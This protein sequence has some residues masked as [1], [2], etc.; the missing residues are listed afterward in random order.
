MNQ[1]ANIIDLQ[2]QASQ[3]A[4]SALD[5]I[6]RKGA[7][8]MLQTAI[9]EEVAVYIEAHQNLRDEHGHRLVVRNGHLPERVVLTGAGPLSVKKPRVDDRRDG[10]KFTSA[11]LPPYMRRSPSIDALI[12]VLYLKGVSTGDFSEALTAILGEGAGSLR[13]LYGVV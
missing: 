2:Q 13:R 4:R 5:E 9:E 8:R 1:Q 11:I 6:V 10:E 12:P 7:R 3:D